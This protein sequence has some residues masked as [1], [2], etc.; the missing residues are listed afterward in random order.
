MV[1]MTFLISTHQSCKRINNKEKVEEQSEIGQKKAEQIEYSKTETNKKEW[2]SINKKNAIDFLLAYGD[3]HKE[4]TV[5]F[6]TRLGNIVIKLYEDTPLHRANFIFL[7]RAGYFNTTCFHRVVPNFIVQGG[8]SES[9]KTIR[10]R[11]KY[12]NYTIPPEFRKNRKHK[13]GA[14]A[15]AREW[16]NNPSKKSTPFEFYFVQSKNGAHHLDGEHTVFGEVID[17]LEVLDKIVSL[18]AGQDQWPY[19]DVFIEASIIK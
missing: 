1:I 8:N 6:K 7:I 19:K 3:S 18:E 13:Y 12:E 9:Y 17:G 2:D 11:N 14:L 5:L 16:E 4:N 10:I 15:A